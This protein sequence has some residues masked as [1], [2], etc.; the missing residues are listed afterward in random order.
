MEIINNEILVAEL[1]WCLTP[2]IAT[3]LSATVCSTG[4]D[5]FSVFMVKDLFFKSLGNL[6]SEKKFTIEK[7]HLYCSK[8]WAGEQLQQI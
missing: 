6:A 5:T 4:I 8:K 7:Q 1:N 3:G 2:L